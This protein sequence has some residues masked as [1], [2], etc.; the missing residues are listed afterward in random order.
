MKKKLGQ[1]G[2]GCKREKPRAQAAC[3]SRERDGKKEEKERAYLLLDNLIDQ[4]LC[5]KR[6][7]HGQ[8]GH[9]VRLFF[10][11]DGSES[12]FRWFLHSNESRST[13]QLPFPI[14]AL[15]LDYCRSTS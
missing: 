4:E 12:H 3:P 11:Q 8:G 9:Q 6:T 7:A 10:K 14:P 2:S 1:D 5:Q 15:L 13:K